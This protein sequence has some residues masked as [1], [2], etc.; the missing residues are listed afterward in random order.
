MLQ[1]FR[2]NEDDAILVPGDDLKTTVAG[3]FEKMG[4]PSEDSVLAAD[5]LVLADLRGVDSHGVSNMLRNYVNQYQSGQINPRPDWKVIRESPSTVTID[6]DRGLGII[7]TPKAMDL[8]IEK[9]KQV[10][11]GMAAIGNARHLGMASYHAM[12]ALKH[13]MIG[14]CMTSCPPSVVPTFGAEPRLGTNPIAVAAPAGKEAPF[15]FDA[16]TSTVAGNKI[17]IARRLGAKLEPGWLA[18]GEGNPIMEEIDTPDTYTLLPLGSTRELGSHKGYGMSC[19][20]DILGGIL[21]GF[22]YG[23]FPG[24]PNFGHY[25]AA[26]SVD[27]FTDAEQFKVTMDEWLQMMKSTKPAPG[28]DRVMVAGQPEAEMEIIRRRDGIPLHEEVVEWLRDTCG[29]LSTPCLV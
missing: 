16:A 7:I 6:S 12:L 13:D 26:Y 1:R 28:H 11:V 15:V 17:G 22:G 25:V 8:A 5:V 29:E 2:V 3:V 23:V 10:G 21:T 27:A 20:V 24:R 4:V 14:V 19:I 9:A 18:D